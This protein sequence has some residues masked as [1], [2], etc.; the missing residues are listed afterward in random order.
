MAATTAYFRYHPNTDKFELVLNYVNADAGV[1]RVFNLQRSVSETIDATFNRIQT[2]ITKELIKRK[3][4]G[5]KRNRSNEPQVSI[6]IELITVPAD[7]TFETWMDFIAF[8][9]QEDAN[10]A[11]LKVNEHS[12]KINYNYP[13]VSQMFM[14][15]VILVGYVCYPSRFEV[16][17]GERDECAYQWYRGLPIAGE[18]T[19]E[20]IQ[21]VEC[22][23][24]NGFFYNVNA[25]DFQHKLKVNS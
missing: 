20:N 16:V 9:Q 13:Y 7:K 6:E 25:N 10:E 4:G 17:F 8:I 12:H 21:W 14:P 23:N 15:A 5:K 2:N 22:N 18:K 19:D 11:A 1:D 3:G 24:G